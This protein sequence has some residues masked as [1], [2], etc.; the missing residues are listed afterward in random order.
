[1]FYY[2]TK[3]C[4]AQIIAARARLKQR[5]QDFK[6]LPKNTSPNSPP[7]YDEVYEQGVKWLDSLANEVPMINDN[8]LQDQ[9][10]ELKLTI[11]HAVARVYMW[12]LFKQQT[13][14]SIQPL[15]SEYTID[16]AK[17]AAIRNIEHAELE[18]QSAQTCVKTG[19]VDL[20]LLEAHF[21]VKTAHWA[22]EQAEISAIAANAA[23]VH[24]TKEWEAANAEVTKLLKERNETQ[25]G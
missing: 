13:V 1:M 7:R 16:M 15:S 11:L 8:I 20:E 9:I 23:L 21:A 22:K 10:E 5:I 3:T 17:A 2:M 6:K 14:Q 12:K 4:D 24:A 19:Y 25:L 18:M